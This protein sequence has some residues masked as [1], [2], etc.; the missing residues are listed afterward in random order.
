MKIFATTVF[1]ALITS[2]WWMIGTDMF[3]MSPASPM[4]IWVRI[5]AVFGLIGLVMLNISD[6][7]T[8]WG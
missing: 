8:D 7:I 2:A 5:F 3:P 4:A 6:I 1:T